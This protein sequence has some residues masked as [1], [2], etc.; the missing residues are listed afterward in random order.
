MDFTSYIFGIF[1]CLIFLLYWKLPDKYR[2]ILLLIANYIFYISF[3]FS[4]ALV[5]TG[6]IF[7]SYIGA[8]FIQSRNNKKVLLVFL[9]MLLLTILGIYKYSAFVVNIYNMLVGRLS[10]PT[11]SVSSSLVA[12]I[13][14]SYYIFQA[15]SYLIDVYRGKIVAEKNLLYYSSRIYEQRRFKWQLWCYKGN[16]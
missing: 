7:T 5:L 11:I 10:L 16:L 1:F 6:I 9:L 3:G 2:P 12:P 4:Y 14:I 15:I 13:G 8:L